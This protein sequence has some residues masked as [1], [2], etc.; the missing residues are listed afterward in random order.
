M[1][2][3]LLADR[4]GEIQEAVF[5]GLRNSNTPHYRTMDEVL[6]QERAASLVESFVGSIRDNAADFS[7][8]LLGIAKERMAEGIPLHEIQI[9]LQILEQKAWQLVVGF[10]PDSEQVR[11][12]SLVTRTIGAAKDQLANFYLGRLARAESRA[13]DLQTRLDKLAR[14][15]DSAPVEEADLPR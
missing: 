14:G 12:L 10:L 6:L 8:Y 4:K 3:E 15:T 5:G 9:A 7:T 13:A 1:L 2:N 11:C